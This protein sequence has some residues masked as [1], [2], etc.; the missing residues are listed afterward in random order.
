MEQLGA[1]PDADFKA[2]KRIV[3]RVI[4]NQEPDPTYGATHFYAPAK[5]PKPDWAIG[6]TPCVIIGNHHFFNN[7]D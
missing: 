1:H 3:E 2:I 5:I 6:K 7:I 4:N